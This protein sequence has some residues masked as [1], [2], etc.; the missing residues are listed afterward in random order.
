VNSARLVWDHSTRR[1][2]P[3]GLTFRGALKFRRSR[4]EAFITEREHCLTTAANVQLANRFSAERIDV[5]K[6]RY[7][8]AIYYST[9]KE[10]YVR[11]GKALR[12]AAELDWFPGGTVKN[13]LSNAYNRVSRR[14]SEISLFNAVFFCRTV[15]VYVIVYFTNCW[16]FKRVS[17]RSH[18]IGDACRYS[19]KHTIGR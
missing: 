9:W 10:W 12:C 11:A 17:L 16:L 13:R 3:P 8:R 19:A 1:A 5:T 14:T 7:G 18:W 2:G 4:I 6:A 15:A